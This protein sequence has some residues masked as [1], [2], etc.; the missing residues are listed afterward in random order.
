M[1]FRRRKQATEDAK[2]A[3][4]EAC[5]KLQEVKERGHEVS[6]V[7]KALKEMGERNHFAEQM[8]EIF[9]RFGGG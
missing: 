1:L 5:E 6:R 4:D 8:E 2:K 9:F 3:L 7:S